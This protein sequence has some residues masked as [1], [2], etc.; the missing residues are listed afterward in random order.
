MTTTLDVFISSKM[1]ELKA[2]R[3]A[4]YDLLPTLD[5]GDIKLHAWVFEEDA[6]ASATIHCGCGIREDYSCK[7]LDH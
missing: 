4:L 3:D 1:V 2:E 5:Y 7:N 6:P